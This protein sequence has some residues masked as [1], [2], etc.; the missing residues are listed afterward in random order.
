MWAA[1]KG[2]TAIVRILLLDSRTDPNLV[3]ERGFTAL[4]KA[5][6]GGYIAIVRMLLKAKA[7]PNLTN[8][9]GTALMWASEKGHTAI[10]RMLLKAKANPNLAGGDG[11]TALILASMNGHV[12]TVEILLNAGA[13]VNLATRNGN[14]AL[15]LASDWGH[16][17][18]VEMLLNAG[19]NPNITN[20]YGETALM[21]ASEKGHTAIVRMLL[22][23]GANP[24]LEAK[25]GKTALTLAFKNRQSQLSQG[26]PDSPITDIIKMLKDAE[27]FDFE[28]LPSKKSSG[29]LDLKTLKVKELR[30]IATKY[31]IRGRS[32]AT[33]KD[34]LIALL[35]ANLSSEDLSQEI[36]SF[37]PDRSFAP[38]RPQSARKERM[39]IFV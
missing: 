12:D 3:D 23:A 21:W 6:N 25:D 19:A 1:E 24:D 33:T 10:V 32:K 37:R 13:N 15:M 8:S 35:R 39:A 36:N 11:I 9:Y 26:L 28:K 27:I 14:T 17:A 22:N 29:S 4:M 5:S 38:R 31:R 30:S 20:K 16:T 34:K 18:I 2:H 7:N